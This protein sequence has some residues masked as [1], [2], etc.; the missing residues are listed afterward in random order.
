MGDAT[1]EVRAGVVEEFAEFEGLITAL[2]PML[3]E[4]AISLPSTTTPCN[5][6]ERACCLG[7][8]TPPLYTM[9]D[10]ISHH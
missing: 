8:C 5:R 7:S 1:E 3:K 2:M 6:N 4:Y 10:R 9:H